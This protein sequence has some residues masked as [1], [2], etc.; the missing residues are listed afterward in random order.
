MDV[1]SLGETIATDV[2]SEGKIELVDKFYS[3]E[4]TGEVLGFSSFRG[5]E[6]Y[7]AWVRQSRVAFPDL[8][9][10]I[11]EMFDA[12]ESIYGKW[13]ARGT[14]NGKLLMLDLEP[15][16]ESV[17]YSGLFIAH[18]HEEQVVQE[19]HCSD[20]VTMMMQLGLFS[21]APLG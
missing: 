6:D 17:E 7:K 15:T 2:W 1:R 21:E 12:G 5:P 20:F 9:V 19:W 3:D 14:H 4:F 10:E 18:F 11:D 8:N 13:T 16:G